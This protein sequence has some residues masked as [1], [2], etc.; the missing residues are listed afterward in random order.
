MRTDP[1]CLRRLESTDP[2]IVELPDWSRLSEHL[3]R[4]RT[5]LANRMREQLCRY[6]PQFLAA[7]AADTE[8]PWALD[9]RQSLPT[10]RAAQRV[11]ETTLP[12][13]LE[14]HRVRR[15]D[16][17]TLRRQQDEAANQ[18]RVAGPL[19][20]GWL[21]EIPRRLTT[22]PRGS[23]PAPVGRHRRLP[24]SDEPKPA[25]LPPRNARDPP[26]GPRDTTSAHKTCYLL[27]AARTELRSLQ[28]SAEDEG[29]QRD[30]SYT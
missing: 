10:P 13:L 30:F 18:D 1:H 6:C 29:P 27:G 20:L 14:K 28:A 17:P 5:R 23:H 16:A 9:L 12:R 19:P 26:W 22:L 4:D 11:R 21:N 7:M 3:T 24:E 15:I 2:T 8:T 25:A